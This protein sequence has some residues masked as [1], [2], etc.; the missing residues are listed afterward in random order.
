M[1]ALRVQGHSPVSICTRHLLPNLGTLVVAQAP[2]RPFTIASATVP[3]LSPGVFA[4]LDL[5][6]SNPDHQRLSITN[7]TVGVSSEPE[8]RWLNSPWA[9]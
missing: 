3:A 2:G 9:S 7:I 6:L 8:Q 5:L 4:P 1:D